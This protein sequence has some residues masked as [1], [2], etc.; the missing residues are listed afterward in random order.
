MSAAGHR[1]AR[2][3]MVVRLL[4]CE[5]RLQTYRRRSD[6]DDDTHSTSLDDLRIPPQAAPPTSPS[7]RSSH[8]VALPASRVSPQSTLRRRCTQCFAIRNHHRPVSRHSRRRQVRSVTN[9][10][11][12][13]TPPLPAPHRPFLLLASTP[14]LLPD[15]ISLSPHNSNSKRLSFVIYSDL[16]KNLIFDYNPCAQSSMWESAQATSSTASA[17]TRL[18]SQA[19]KVRSFF[20]SFLSFIP[21]NPTYPISSSEST[22]TYLIVILP[23]FYLYPT[24]PLFHLP[25]HFANLQNVDTNAFAGGILSDINMS[26]EGVMPW[27]KLMFASGVNT[28]VYNANGS[29]MTDH[30]QRTRPSPDEAAA[31][32]NAQRRLRLHIRISITYCIT[33]CIMIPRTPHPHPASTS[34]GEGQ[35]ATL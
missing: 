10:S 11:A 26:D 29:K 8:T 3:A 9:K 28:K 27:R 2:R 4:G 6:Y 17:Q 1:V 14:A 21:P 23:V 16:L 35:A 31:Q 20:A 13:R 32:F 12:T 5:L 18:S 34:H 15:P 7:S 19:I 24:L 33:W 30:P 25:S 22:D